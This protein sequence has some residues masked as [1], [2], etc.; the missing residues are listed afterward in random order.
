VSTIRARHA[1]LR[2]RGTGGTGPQS[3]VL[4]TLRAPVAWPEVGRLG[5]RRRVAACSPTGSWGLAR[6][7]SGETAPATLQEHVA[8]GPT[9]SSTAAGSCWENAHPAFTLNAVGGGIAVAHNGKLTNTAALAG[10]LIPQESPSGR[11]VQPRATS[12][13]D[14]LAHLLGREADLP[15]EGAAIVHTRPG[16]EDLT[17]TAVLARIGRVR[18]PCAAWVPGGSPN[19]GPDTATATLRPCVTTRPTT[20]PLPN[21]EPEVAR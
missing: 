3:R 12:D 13:P 10:Q 15:L 6:Q 21:P 16:R 1:G 20:L 19:P 9:H 18:G 17:G 2:G 8:I 11:P 14:L 7:V 4:P 5:R